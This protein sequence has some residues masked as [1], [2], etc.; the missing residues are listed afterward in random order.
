MVHARAT[1]YALQGFAQLLIGIG[2]AAAIVEQDQVHLLRAIQFCTAAWAR[3][4]V[5]VS[6]DV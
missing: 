2:L 4:H 5:E 3:N 6:G 1:T